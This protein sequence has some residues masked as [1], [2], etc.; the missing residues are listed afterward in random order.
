MTISN[1]QSNRNTI[2]NVLPKI[3]TDATYAFGFDGS[4]FRHY[5]PQLLQHKTMVPC[6]LQK[7]TY[8]IDLSYSQHV[9]FYNELHLI[10]LSFKYEKMKLYAILNL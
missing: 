6:S 4:F 5:A 3:A 1:K 9:A 2:F 10:T 8:D 7:V